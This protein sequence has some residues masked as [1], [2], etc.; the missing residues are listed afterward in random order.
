M[1]SVKGP[2]QPR[3]RRQPGAECPEKRWK[4]S[5]ESHSGLSRVPRRIPHCNA[6]DCC[7]FFGYVDTARREVVVAKVG[8]KVDR[9]PCCPL[10]VVRP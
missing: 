5:N 10:L 6:D 9:H 7:P 4:R 3:R 2:S 1:C 8:S